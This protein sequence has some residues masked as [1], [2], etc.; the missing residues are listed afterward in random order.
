MGGRQFPRT[1]SRKRNITRADSESQG[2]TQEVVI[3]PSTPPDHYNLGDSIG[4][5]AFI[6]AVVAVVLNFPLWA[7]ALL[8]VASCVGIFVFGLKSHWTYR[9]PKWMS[10]V[11]ASAF[12][13]FLGSIAIPQLKVQWRTINNGERHP[14]LPDNEV[15]PHLQATLLLDSV[16]RRDVSFHW[17][18]ENISRFDVAGIRVSARNESWQDDETDPSLNRGL[19]AGGKLDVHGWPKVF[20]PN[21]SS[22]LFTTLHYTSYITGINKTFSSTYRFLVE[23]DRAKS[24]NP[25]EWIEQEGGDSDA[26]KSASILKMWSSPVGSMFLALDEL[27]P[28][29]S[30]NVVELKGAQKQFV[31]DPVGRTVSYQMKSN[32]GHTLE[33]K[34]RLSPVVARHRMVMTWDYQKGE[35]QLAVDGTYEKRNAS[36][37]QE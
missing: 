19:P 2:T 35:A 9:W 27:Q 32:S 8:L 37:E 34:T 3:S 16:N 29:G 18:V 25:A 11:T 4:L 20:M 6:F 28:S 14:S 1:H 24:I 17:L 26:N 30:P 15:R 22:T 33:F 31:F 13:F 5:L 23:P 12:V 21:R 7:K 36:K 10:I